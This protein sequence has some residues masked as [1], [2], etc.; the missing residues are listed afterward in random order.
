MSGCKPRAP[1]DVSYHTCLKKVDD[2][3]SHSKS[4]EN[5]KSRSI[6]TALTQPNLPNITF[7]V[8]IL[9]YTSS[10]YLEKRNAVHKV[11]TMIGRDVFMNKL[12]TKKLFEKKKIGLAG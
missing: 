8:I 12:Q 11:A 5:A 2:Q 6:N 7:S 10:L 1:N 3:E 9:C 4:V